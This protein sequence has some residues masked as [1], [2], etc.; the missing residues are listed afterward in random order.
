MNPEVLIGKSTSC[1]QAIFKWFSKKNP[2][3]ICI[4]EREHMAKY[5]QLVYLGNGY[6]VLPSR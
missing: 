6:T 3:Y 2:L 1:T 5:Y 4:T